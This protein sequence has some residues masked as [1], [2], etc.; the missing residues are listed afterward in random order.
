M[1]LLQFGTVFTNFDNVAQID[2]A[3]ILTG[4]FKFFF[5]VTMLCYVVFTIIV[6]RQVQVMRNTLITPI[7]P[8]V[9]TVAILHLMVALAVL[10]LFFI[11]L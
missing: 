5:I 7:S 4:V 6:I 8:I 3:G 2:Q 11:I 10:A 9:L 1:S